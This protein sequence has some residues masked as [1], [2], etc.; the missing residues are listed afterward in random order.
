MRSVKKALLLMLCAGTGASAGE[1]P[2]EGSASY[3]THYVSMSAT[4][5]KMGERIV[6]IYE[7]SGITRNDAGE[8][9]FH[10]MGTRCVGMREANGA[11]VI[12][13]GSCIDADTDG[14]QVFSTYEANAKTG[15]HVFVGGTGKYQGITGTAEYTLQPVKVPE[16]ARPMTIVPHKA[17]WKLP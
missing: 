7:S 16:G 3:T 15:R 8:G 10:D 2:K 17:T 5:M 6:A 1:F 11:E 4:P 9:A 14:D 12:N 13:R